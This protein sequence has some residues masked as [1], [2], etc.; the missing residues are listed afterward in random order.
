VSTGAS[1]LH[2][3]TTNSMNYCNH[4]PIYSKLLDDSMSSYD[5]PPPPSHCTA[6]ASHPQTSA[7]APGGPRYDP[8]SSS[9]HIP[10]L[11]EVHPYWVLEHQPGLQNGHHQTGQHPHHH[12]PA[13]A[14]ASSRTT[15]DRRPL[16]ASRHA[17][18]ACWRPLPPH[19][20]LLTYYCLPSY[21]LT[22]LLA[23]CW[24]YLSAL[25]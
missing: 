23:Y 13:S 2:A 20:T 6:P 10:R 9:D 17:P 15:D 19:G 22:Y 4:S 16:P 14:A 12:L 1:R 25:V 11:H 18:P 5:D 3:P 7:G 21:L 24:P 8:H